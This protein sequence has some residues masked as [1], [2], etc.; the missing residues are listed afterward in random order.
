MEPTDL[1]DRLIRTYAMKREDLAIADEAERLRHYL[2]GL[3]GGM[4]EALF[5]LLGFLADNDALTPEEVDAG[6]EQYKATYWDTKAKE[7]RT[8]IIRQLTEWWVAQGIPVTKTLHY[9]NRTG[10]GD[11]P[12]IQFLC[13]EYEKVTGLELKGVTAR[14]ELEKLGY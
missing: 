8:D 3:S 11:S 1:R 2:A 4:R 7:L 5:D 6:L 10:R 13:E 12:L 14:T 9:Q